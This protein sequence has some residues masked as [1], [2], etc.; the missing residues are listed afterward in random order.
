MHFFLLYLSFYF[1][2]FSHTIL[3]FS[4]C[5]VI[6]SSLPAILFTWLNSTMFVDSHAVLRDYENGSN[7]TP[8]TIQSLC[9]MVDCYSLHTKW[10]AETRQLLSLFLLSNYLF[11]GHWTHS[12]A[13]W[14]IGK[15]M[16]GLMVYSSQHGASMRASRLSLGYSGLLLCVLPH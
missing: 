8:P 6:D 14:K 3:L 7:H 5:C 13:A 15:H 16:M 1:F 4:L 11:F 12:L 2:V 10:L 9:Q